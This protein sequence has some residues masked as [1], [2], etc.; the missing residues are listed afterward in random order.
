MSASRSWAELSREHE[1]LAG[2]SDRIE[3]RVGAAPDAARGQALS[4]DPGRMSAG[5][6]TS[7]PA[8]R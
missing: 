1:R 5:T 2:P 4:S 8:P 6:A 3:A 7:V